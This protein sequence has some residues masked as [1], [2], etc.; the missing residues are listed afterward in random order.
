MDG[1]NG[2][3][4]IE[5]ITVCFGMSFVYWLANETAL[6]PKVLIIAAIVLGFL[7]WNFP[8][9][10]I[11]MGDVG[12]NFLGLLFGILS[13]QAFFISRQLFWS[14]L[15]LLGVFITDASIT[16][17]RRS[18]QGEKIYQ[19]H[20]NHA[21]QNAARKIGSHIPVTLFV[22]VVNITWLLPLAGLVALQYLNGFIGLL[23]A[24]LPLCGLVFA[25]QEKIKL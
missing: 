21:Y 6:V 3:A 22:L 19:A 7:P 4:S 23:I 24:Y 2:I 8:K 1:I 12:S 5:A 11:F 15:I 14:W 10:K 25:L 17:M 16:L 13:L 20:C 9:A 18:L